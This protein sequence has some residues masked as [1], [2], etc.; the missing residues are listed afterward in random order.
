MLYEH[1]DWDFPPTPEHTAFDLDI[2][3]YQNRLVELKE[4]YKDS[5]DLNFGMELGLQPHLDSRHSARF[6][7]WDPFDFVIGSSHVTD[8][9]DPYYRVFFENRARKKPIPPILNP[10]WKI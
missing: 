3:A 1:L 5:I 2:P 6:E 4:K 8:G 9:C 10:S 7:E